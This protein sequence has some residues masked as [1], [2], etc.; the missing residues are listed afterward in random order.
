MYTLVFFLRAK[1]IF[2]DTVLVVVVSLMARGTGMT[3][4]INWFPQI[5][6]RG[7][8]VTDEGLAERISG[9]ISVSIFVID[10]ATSDEFGISP[11]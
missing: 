9:G 1:S 6:A 3:N 7:M 10:G 8:I 5:V 2:I 4:Y 11:Y